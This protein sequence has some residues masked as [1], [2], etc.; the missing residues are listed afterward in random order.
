M[1]ENP[2]GRSPGHRILFDPSPIRPPDAARLHPSRPRPEPIPV[3]APRHARAQCHWP[4]R[5]RT[6]HSWRPRRPHRIPR[7]SRSRRRIRQA[8]IRLTPHN[9]GAASKGSMVL[10]RASRAHRQAGHRRPVRPPRMCLRHRAVLLLRVFHPRRAI[11]D[12]LVLSP[13]PR[14]RPRLTRRRRPP[15]RQPHPPGRHRRLMLRRMVGSTRRQRNH[16]R[17][18]VIRQEEGPIRLLL[19]RNQYRLGRT[20]HRRVRRRRPFGR[21]L[22]LPGRILDR[23]GTSLRPIAHMSRAT[24]WPRRE[25]NVQHRTL[26]VR[27]TPRLTSTGQGTARVRA[28]CRSTSPRTTRLRRIARRPISLLEQS[29][30][31]TPMGIRHKTFHE[32]TIRR[33]DRT[34]AM[35]R[36]GARFRLKTVGTRRPD[37]WIV[38]CRKRCRRLNTMSRRASSTGRRRRS[39]ATPTG[40]LQTLPRRSPFRPRTGWC[41]KELRHI[42]RAPRG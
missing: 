28:D 8:R 31:A 25:A 3:C 30:A 42:S 23:R 14:R 32:K 41:P 36:V 18:T 37:R 5:R 12:K 24:T 1:L 11:P 10:N 7:P 13:P 4:I 38:L 17:R 35:L 39:A 6:S 9:P 27:V 19:G 40:R 34:P 15:S 29:S 33:L 2:R 16:Q 21:I 20:L 22:R 26:Q